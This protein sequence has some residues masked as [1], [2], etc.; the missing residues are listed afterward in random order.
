[1]NQR[2]VDALRRMRS[3]AEIAVGYAQQ[4]RNWSADQMITDA[5]ARRVEQVA[6]IAKYQFPLEL[7]T[8]VPELPWDGVTGMRDRLVDDYDKINIRL[9]RDVVEKDLPA[10]IVNIDR[11]LV[12]SS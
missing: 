2:G 1:L 3:N 8:E 10:L 11:V 7:R 5:V 4:G 9:L 12:E 6:E